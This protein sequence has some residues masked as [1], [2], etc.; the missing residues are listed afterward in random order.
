MKTLRKVSLPRSRSCSTSSP[1]LIL[2]RLL[3]LLPLQPPLQLLLQLPLKQ[4]RLRLHQPLLQPLRPLVLHCAP[5]AY[6]CRMPVHF[7]KSCAASF[8]RMAIGS[9]ALSFLRS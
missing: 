3:H 6:R 9:Q 4:L 7:P 5:Q 8:Q 1:R 2:C